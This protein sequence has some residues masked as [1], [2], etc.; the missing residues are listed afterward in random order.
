MSQ[1]LKTLAGYYHQSHSVWDIGCDHGMLGLSFARTE[2]V[3]GIHLVDPSS[4]VIKVLRNKLID[5][6]IT[7]PDFISIHEIKGQEVILNPESKT[8]FIAGMGGKEIE[9]IVQQLIPQLSR[10]DRLVLSPHR[11]ILELRQYLH[12]SSMGLLE[13]RIFKEDGQFYQFLVLEKREELTK[14]SPYGEEVFRG[15]IGEEYKKHL[16]STFKTHQDPLSKAFLTYL[17]GHI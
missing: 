2:T 5:T 16:I 9:K 10:E 3:K 4:D 17:T 12:D 8:V 14:I 11:N 7:I 6:Y 13:E 1:R 15:K